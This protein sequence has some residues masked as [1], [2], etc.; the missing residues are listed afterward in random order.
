MQ[1]VL[2]DH[3]TARISTQVL[4]ISWLILTILELMKIFPFV[5]TT[6]LILNPIIACMQ[7]LVGE[8]WS[9]F[10]YTKISMVYGRFW[11]DTVSLD[12]LLMIQN[13]A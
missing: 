8:G 10:V 7:N 11:P 13:I 12:S 2:R 3:G 9:L 1:T 4:R 5:K 6:K